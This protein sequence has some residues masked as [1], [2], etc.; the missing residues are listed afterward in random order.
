MSL[1]HMA[2]LL[3]PTIWEHFQIQHLPSA[4]IHHSGLQNGWNSIFTTDTENKN[5]NTSSNDTT[6]SWF[7]MNPYLTCQTAIQSGNMQFN[8]IYLYYA[9]SLFTEVHRAIS[10]VVSEWL[11]MTESERHCKLSLSVSD[12]LQRHA[13]QVHLPATQRLLAAHHTSEQRGR[14]LQLPRYR[15]EIT[16]YHMHSVAISLPT[17]VSGNV[18][19]TL[20]EL[21]ER[22]VE[23]QE[24]TERGKY[25]ILQLWNLTSKSWLFKIMPPHFF[26]TSIFGCNG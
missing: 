11:R 1:D 6:S 24:D 23:R 12:P 18:C 8:R 7:Q 5:K 14:S 16:N 10:P 4:L 19:G 26:Y 9:G 25:H 15:H 22:Q 13:N 20:D 3:D 21:Q 2:L 17:C